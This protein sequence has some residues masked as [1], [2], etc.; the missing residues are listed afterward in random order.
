MT[1]KPREAPPPTWQWRFS[2][3][4]GFVCV[5]AVCLLFGWIFA[6]VHARKRHDNVVQTLE[7]HGFRFLH[8][9]IDPS[10]PL[11]AASWLEF[12]DTRYSRQVYEAYTATPPSLDDLESLDVF[13]DLRIL[14]IR[15]ATLAQESMNLI[16]RLPRV[17][18]LS[19]HGSHLAPSSLQRLA[20]LESLIELDLASVTASAAEF[21]AVGRCP[22]LES[23]N[24]DSSNLSDDGLAHLSKL[25]RLTRLSV[26]HTSISDNG[27]RHLIKLNRL[28]EL[29]V[30]H[31]SISDAGLARL[32]DLQ[33][34]ELLDVKKSKVTDAGVTNLQYRLPKLTVVVEEGGGYPNAASLRKATGFGSSGAFTTDATLR[35][36]RS[37]T[38]LRNLNLY[39]APGV[40]D[41]GLIHLRTLTQLQFLDIRK[42]AVTDQ[43]LVALVGLPLNRL[44][45]GF[46]IGDAGV[47]QMARI[48]SLEFVE[49]SG[50]RITD[51]GLKFLGELPNLR[52]LSLRAGEARGEG[53][54]FLKSLDQLEE[55]ELGGMSLT[56]VG[57]QHIAQAP[58]LKRLELNQINIEQD[59]ILTLVRAAK[60]ERLS[61]WA[62]SIDQACLEHLPAMKSLRSIS[63]YS[64][65]VTI[66]D[67]KKLRAA[68]PNCRVWVQV[69]TEQAVEILAQP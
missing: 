4:S 46:E 21:E 69:G 8:E 48:K 33:E 54:R 25:N 68:R 19:L 5:T 67:G 52:T 45:V 7:S 50:S 44:L 61:F 39:E 16:C 15:Q 12:V 36:L 35:W 51:E 20:E 41:E 66:E 23:L 55:L 43:G 11:S 42:T 62:T 9:H 58:R 29:N 34:L 26:A 63:F 37:A 1:S 2:L 53:F 3:K 18:K 28:K 49:V 57:A 13:S 22:N 14:H 32:T 65:N 30:A 40:T 64:T 24:L 38:Q 10:N 17:E 27:L 6:E 47:E 59:A 56:T 31:T 60:V